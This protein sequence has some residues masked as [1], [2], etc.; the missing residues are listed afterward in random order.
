MKKALAVWVLVLTTNLL[1]A[2]TN[3]LPTTGNV[4]IGTTTPTT[5]LEIVGGTDWTSNHWIKSLKLNNG[6]AIQLSSNAGYFGIGGTDPEGLYFFSTTVNDAS[7]PAKYLM[8][9]RSNG[10]VGIGTISPSEMLSVKGK[11]RSQEI[12]V[13]AANWPDYVFAKDYKLPSLQATEQ[14]I[15]EKGHLPGIPSAEEVKANGIDL[16]EMNAK[17]LKKIEELTL[18]LIASEKRNSLQNKK[19]QYL[20][21]QKQRDIKYLKSKVK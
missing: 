11:I 1:Y 5:K 4:G 18:H 16:G 3:I 21:E 17:L 9:M 12:K 2:Q 10:N 8:V 14:H 13:E 6:H 19:Q 7:A 15:K 20:I